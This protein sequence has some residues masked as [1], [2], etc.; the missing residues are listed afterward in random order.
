ML[1]E[2]VPLGA[3]VV[4]EQVSAALTKSP[5]FVPAMVTVEMLRLALPLLINVT[6]LSVLVVATGRLLKLKLVV[7]RLT[8]AEVPVPL[9]LT[10]WGLLAALSE[11]INDAVRFPGADGANSIFTEQVPLGATVAPEQV[12]ALLAKSPAF[13]PV[14]VSVD[15]V[16]LALPLLVRV[17]PFAALVVPTA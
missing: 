6:A 2:H 1:T 9:R 13:V 16:R 3:T 10:V 8:L 15:M 7:L 14:I 11:K 17:T 12:S 4:P 5:A